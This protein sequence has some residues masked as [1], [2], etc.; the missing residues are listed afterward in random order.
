MAGTTTVGDEAAA[1]GSTD[2]TSIAVEVVVVGRG[3]IGAAAARHLATAGARVALVGPDEPATRSVDLDIVASHWDEGRI[4]RVLDP[5]PQWAKRALR[6]IDRYREV[7]RA[8]GIRFF[9]E[10][11]HLR[12]MADTDEVES[13]E[14]V[15]ADL[16]VATERLEGRA[17]A[18]R[19]PALSLDPHLTGLYQAE[20]AGHVSARGQVAAQTRAAERRGA[21]VRRTTAV[22]VRRTPDAIEVDLAD[23]GTVRA[24]RAL[25][26]TGAF[27]N[28]AGL[29]T[30]PLDLTVL[31]R[32]VVL[33]RLGAR[34]LRRLRGLPS[35]IHRPADPA[36]GCYLLPPIRYPDGGWY[37][38]IG[39]PTD[40][41]TLD[42]RQ[43]LLTWFRGVGD[44]RAA[45]AL[46]ERLHRLVPDLRPEGVRTVACATTHTPSGQPLVAWLDDRVAVAVGGNGAAAKSADEI[47]RRGARLVSGGGPG[48]ASGV[49]GRGGVE[50][51][52][53]GARAGNRADR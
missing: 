11:G 6:S 48:D 40:D 9:H 2:T 31:G 52:D 51:L 5:D 47:G 22:G 26:A 24:E 41:P 14:G 25:L 28:A 50:R 32:T 20:R 17:L 35:V 12:V 42:T 16:G 7:E 21:V 45:D 46:L 53:G 18:R 39:G 1:T 13:V 30:E 8:S 34:D 49:V 19:F 23:G 43:A 10:V 29:T 33:V 37:L 38:K 4:T 3:L 44:A 27:T 36:H 15:A